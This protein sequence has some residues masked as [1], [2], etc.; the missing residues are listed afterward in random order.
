KRGRA[1]LPSVAARSP[2]PGRGAHS[3]R[4]RHRVLRGLPAD[5]RDG[6]R[7]LLPQAHSDRRLLPDGGRPPARTRLGSENTNA[8]G[9]ARRR[10]CG[11]N[12][13]LAPAQKTRAEQTEADRK[14]RERL[15]RDG[16]RAGAG[17]VTGNAAAAGDAAAAAGGGSRAVPAATTERERRR[18]GERQHESKNGDHQETHGGSNLLSMAALILK[19]H[20]EALT[21]WNHDTRDEM[22]GQTPARTGVQPAAGCR[23]DG[24]ALRSDGRFLR[25]VRTVHYHG[26][27]H[28]R[29]RA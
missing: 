21:G 7:R 4:R 22:T 28:G 2:R 12:G 15:R 14:Q 25:W 3:G 29:R 18:G 10:A 13:V 27:R 17:G 20:A 5:P 26:R 16:D 19:A 6:F 9:R 8:A 11:A 24:T 1:R 23:Y